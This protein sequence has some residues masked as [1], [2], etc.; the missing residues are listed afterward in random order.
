[1]PA[2]PAGQPSG[3][4]RQS[5]VCHLSGDEA[6]GL[7]ATTSLDQR[8]QPRTAPAALDTEAACHPGVALHKEC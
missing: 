6:L 1:M 7:P 8:Y 2:A 4:L 3:L 5:G